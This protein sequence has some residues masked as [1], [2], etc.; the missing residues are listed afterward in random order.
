MLIL[1]FNEEN[2]KKTLKLFRKK[3]KNIVHNKSSFVCKSI[4]FNVVEISENDLFN[5]EI[6]SLLN[7]YKG[8]VLDTRNK[9]INS[10][11]SSYL[12]D[13][14][15]YVKRAVLSSFID[16]VSASD[17][18]DIVIY[19]ENFRFSQ[20]YVRLAQI[21]RRLVI[22]CNENKEIIMFS[23]Y[24]YNKFGLNVFVNDESFVNGKKIYLNLDN[25]KKEGSI[26]LNNGDKIFEIVPDKK[27]FTE[28]SFVNKLMN[29]GVSHDMACAVVEVVPYKKHIFSEEQE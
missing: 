24:C 25:V 19:D 4:I 8:A 22:Y 20:E 27:Y 3:R 2:N 29:L 28:N 13:Y 1:K 14:S 12:Y 9:E 15:F 5:Q 18:R 17:I 26:T 7:K 16:F 10:H 21:C 23:K 6:I 11:L